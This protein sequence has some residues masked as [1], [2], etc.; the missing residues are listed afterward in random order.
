M[1]LRPLFFF[2]MIT[3]AGSLLRAQPC[4]FLIQAPTNPNVTTILE[5]ASLPGIKPGDVICLQ[6]GHYHQ[7]LIRDIHG[8]PGAPILMRNTDGRVVIQNDAHYGISVRNTRHFQILGDGEESVSYGIAVMKVGGGAGISFDQ[9]TSHVNLMHTEVANT[10]FAGIVAKTDPDC[11]FFSLREHFVMQDVHIG[12]NYIHDTGMEGIYAGSSFFGGFQ[13]HCNGTDT[14]V[15]PH[16]LQG[17]YVFNNLIERTGRNGIQVNSAASDCHIFDNKILY[18][19]QSETHNQMGGIQIGGG[20]S[21]D[22]YNNHISKGK[23]S[24]IEVFGQGNIRIFNNLIEDPGLLYRPNEPH[25]QFPKHGIY[26]RDTQANAPANILIAH[27]NIMNPKSD[28]ILFTNEQAHGSRIHNNIIINPG[29][30]QQIRSEAYIHHPGIG[31]SVSNNLMLPNEQQAG[32]VNP[33]EGDYALNWFS[34]AVDNGLDMAVFGIHFDRFYTPRPLGTGYDIGAHEANPEQMAGEIPFTKA[35][36]NP[37]KNTLKIHVY[38]PDQQK[39][40][41]KIFSMNGQLVYSQ[42]RHMVSAG[43]HELTL[44]TTNLTQGMYLLQLIIGSD[45]QSFRMIRLE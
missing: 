28:G 31:L 22:C 35:Y 44:D 41:I 14:I 12:H 42:G 23:G 1:R 2:L 21:C 16:L 40:Q 9:R 36:P 6:A 25:S 3:Y 17:A 19:S 27:N 18:D 24:G 13:L 20:S 45:S 15:F 39:T 30:Y 37:F 26:L 11:S 34:P 10:L 38:L 7:I 32:F 8:E 5:P 33:G 4:N 29:S 43:N